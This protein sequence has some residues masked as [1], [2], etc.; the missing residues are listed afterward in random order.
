LVVN[1]CISALGLISWKKVY[2][3]PSWRIRSN[4]NKLHEHPGAGDNWNNEEATLFS[5]IFPSRFLWVFH[6]LY[7]GVMS[8][9]KANVLLSLT[10]VGSW[11]AKVRSC[12][13]IFHSS[14]TEITEFDSIICLNLVGSGCCIWIQ[15]FR[16]SGGALLKWC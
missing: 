1:L 3:D 2:T 4:C 15:R 10:A 16:T 12:N 9:K 14:C 8:Q 5:K 6:F 7:L 13:F 11:R